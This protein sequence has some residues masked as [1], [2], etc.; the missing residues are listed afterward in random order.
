LFK[1]CFVPG[2]QTPTQAPLWQAEATQAVAFA[3]APFALHVSTSLF[4]QRLV[5]GV[6]TPWHTPATHAW[7]EHAVPLCQVP[8][9][10]HVCGV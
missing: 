3:Q 2:T 10:S 6:Q 5:F 1:H 9:P 8:V 4:V 7:F